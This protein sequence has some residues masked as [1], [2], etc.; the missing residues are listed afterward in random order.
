MSVDEI[1]KVVDVFKQ[2]HNEYQGWPY[3]K[4]LVK[5]VSDKY[6]IEDVIDFFETLD[7]ITT[8]G[9]RIILILVGHGKI[10]NNNILF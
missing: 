6:Y 9:D 7:R 5:Y 10:I 1:C 4:S 3:Y 2:R 8:E